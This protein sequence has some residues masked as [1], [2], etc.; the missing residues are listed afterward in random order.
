M[1]L[2]VQPALR[3]PA[4]PP[5]ASM[6]PSRLIISVTINSRMSPRVRARSSAFLAEFLPG[7]FLKH[8]SARHHWYKLEPNRA[9][10]QHEGDTVATEHNDIVNLTDL[11]AELLD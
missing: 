2:T 5:G 3:Y 4:S 6:T 10:C 8:E 1:P 9:K 7:F 11:S